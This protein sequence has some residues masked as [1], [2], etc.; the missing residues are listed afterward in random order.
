MSTSEGNGRS[1]S[2]DP[3]AERRA[4]ARAIAAR[5]RDELGAGLVAGAIYGSVAHDAADIHSDLEM[6]LVSGETFDA[7][8]VH[9]FERGVM[10]EISRQPEARLLTAARRVRQ[11]WGIEADKYRHNIMLFNHIGFFPRL[12]AAIRDLADEAFEAAMR[13]AWWF[14]YESRGKLKNALRAD[15]RARV[16]YDGWLFAYASAMR[17]RCSRLAT[18]LASRLRWSRCGSR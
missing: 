12:H 7:E 9:V 16:S 5:A 11:D 2:A 4:I 6:M 1:T 8:E 14:A 10:V 17:V 13:E 3:N 18:A 15:E